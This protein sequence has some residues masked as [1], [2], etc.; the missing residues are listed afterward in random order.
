MN[1]FHH[2]IERKGW[3]GKYNLKWKMKMEIFLSFQWSGRKFI[4]LLKKIGN[5]KWSNLKIK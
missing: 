3:E 5:S 1:K 2:V 4:E